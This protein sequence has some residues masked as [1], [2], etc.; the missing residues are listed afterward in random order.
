MNQPKACAWVEMLKYD[1]ICQ[2]KLTP[3]LMRFYTGKSKI[4]GYRT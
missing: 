1:R 3:A 2:D 4:E